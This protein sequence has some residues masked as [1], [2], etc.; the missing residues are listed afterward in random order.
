MSDSP[1]K[2]HEVNPDLIRCLALFFVL[3]IHFYTHCGIYDAAYT[4]VSAFLTVL[5]RTLVTTSV[6]LFVMLTGYL[7][8][9]KKLS[10]RYYLGILRLL[11]MYLICAVT[12]LLYRHFYLGEAMTVRSFL[13]AIVN[14]TASEYSWYILLYAGLFMMIPFLNLAYGSLNCRGHKR[15]LVVSFF[16]L[17]ALPFS[18]L[19]VFV[20]LCAYWWQRIWPLTF[21]FAGAYIGEYRPRISAKKCALWL[22]AALLVFSAFNFFVY[23]PASPLKLHYEQAF[24]YTHEGLQNAILA[25]LVFLFILNIDCS[26]WS[27]KLTGFAASV[28]KYIYGAFLFSSMTD[29]FV[30]IWLNRFVPVPEKRFAFFLIALP[31]SYV[32]SVLLA[33]LADKL[34]NVM[35]RALRPAA[36]RLTGWLYR[37][38]APDAAE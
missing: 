18:A 30:Y 25:P 13:G 5:L 26:R 14:F 27:E 31:V 28:S 12:E 34:V 11:E 15:L 38:I 36:A 8:R 2:V 37:L 20:N 22:C 4:G 6:A 9:T 23:S 1:A 17:S 16:L 21:Y 19:N 10:A 24:P 29:S 3:S 33:V 32:A 35:D 7:Q